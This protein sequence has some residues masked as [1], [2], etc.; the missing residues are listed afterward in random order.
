M[1]QSDVVHGPLPFTR[2]DS[3]DVVC[4]WREVGAHQRHLPGGLQGST[5]IVIVS[6]IS[7]IVLQGNWT[8]FP[9]GLLFASGVGRMQPHLSYRAGTITPRN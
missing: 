8:E 5:K 1:S 2:V 6:Q 3:T 7:S 9:V 4:F